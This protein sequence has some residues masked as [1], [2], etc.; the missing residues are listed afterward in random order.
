LIGYVPQAASSNRQFPISVRQVVLQGRLAGRAA[1]FHQYQKRDYEL[2][3]QALIRLE[4]HDLAERQIGQL[5]GGQWQRVLIARA[6]VVQPQILILDEPTSGLD[7]DGS[8]LVYE[9]L[10]ELNREISIVMATHDTIAIGSCVKDIA[11]LNRTL[12]YHGEPEISSE[13]AMQVYGC[14]V[15]LIAHGVPHRVMRQHGGIE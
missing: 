3:E 5:S 13:L 15:E 12:Y 4:I 9:L 1:F 14:P 2:V 7:A 10:Q 6:L 8:T 11:C